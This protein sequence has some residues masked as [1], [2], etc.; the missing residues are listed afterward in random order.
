MQQVL[1]IGERDRVCVFTCPGVGSGSPFI[2]RQVRFTASTSLL[3]RF[4]HGSGK[5]MPSIH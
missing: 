2:Y 3:L 4:R 1:F 5:F